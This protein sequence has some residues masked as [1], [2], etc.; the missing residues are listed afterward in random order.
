MIAPFRRIDVSVYIVVARNK[1]HGSY[2]SK[3]AAKFCSPI[4]VCFLLV[5]VYHAIRNLSCLL[6]CDD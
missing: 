4:S 1:S 6:L 2:A 3:M 5:K